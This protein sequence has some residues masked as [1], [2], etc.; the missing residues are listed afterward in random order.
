[1]AL[2]KYWESLGVRPDAV[3]GHS[4]GEYA[5]LHVAGVLSAADALFLVGERARMLERECK[6]GSH[7]MLAVRASLAEI[8]AAAGGRPFEV[9]CL[10]GPKDT[11]LGGT[12]EELEVLAGVLEAAG[13]R[14]FHLD[15]AFAFHSAQTDPVLEELEETARKGV[16]FLPP[17][18]PV[19]SPLLGRVVFDGSS[20]NANYIRR[21]TRE[22]VNFL[23]AIKTASRMLT[24]DETMAWIEIGPH[25]VCMGFARS[26]MPSIKAAVPSLRRGEDNWHTM[27]NSLATLHGV[28]V[29]I[30][31]NEFHRPFEGGLR[32]LDLP[33]YAWN[34]K[35]HWIQ[36][37]GDW[38]LTKGNTFYDEEKKAQAAAASNPLAV[39]HSELRT[40]LVH[41]VTEAEFSG[42]AGRVVVQSDLMQADFLSAAWGHQ[43]NKAGVVTSVSKENPTVYELELTTHI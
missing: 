22:T 23:G 5:A 36:Y 20:I 38:A 40:S 35:T 6:A 1:M 30:N 41:R 15:V 25:P 8:E 43:M 13:F 39:L 29:Q 27:S 4:L 9:A 12:V 28:G 10:N 32:L 7:K 42:A 16:V 19:I 37:N 33:T 26:I 34:D 17:S 2:V 11:V 21:A 14:C 24:V 31:W 18:L 3:V